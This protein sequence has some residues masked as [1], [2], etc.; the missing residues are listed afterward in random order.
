MV[1]GP[2]PPGTGVIAPAT[3]TARVEVDVA[4]EPALPS[5]AVDAVDADVDHR[6]ARLDP[7]ALHHARPADR[8]DQDVGAAADRGEVA[9]ARMRDRHR[10]AVA[11]QQLR[12]RLA[13]DVR[14]ADHHRARA[15][16]GRRAGRAAASGSRAACRAPAPSARSRAARRWRRGSRRRPSPGA[17]ALITRA[18]SMCA[19]SGSCTRMP[20]TAGSRFSRVDQR[21]QLG[22]GWSTAASRCSTECMPRL[23]RSAGPCCARRPGSP[24]R[25]RPAPP[26]GRA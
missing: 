19:G 9:G 5:G 15:R 21:Q 4:D 10:A 13:D 1:I 16:R 8:G 7:V 20:W 14:A 26:R 25:R 11:Q 17:I 23:E 22:L 3:A 6:R 12:H 24:D 2:T 18:S